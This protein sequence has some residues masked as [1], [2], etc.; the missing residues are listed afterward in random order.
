MASHRSTLFIN[1]NIFP[2]SSVLFSCIFVLFCINNVDQCIDPIKKLI[3]FAS[4]VGGEVDVEVRKDR[5]YKIVSMFEAADFGEETPDV[6]EA[7]KQVLKTAL[8]LEGST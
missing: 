6:L 1:S 8:G 4:F 3:R 2:K 5:A 7:Q